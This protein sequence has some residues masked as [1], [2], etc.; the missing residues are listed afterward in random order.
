MN[1]KLMI[2]GRQVIITNEHATSSY[3][4]PVVLVDG[5]ITD[6]GVEYEADRCECNILDMLADAAGIHNG[7][8][9]RRALRSLADEMLPDNPRGG[10]YDPVI[11]EFV[12]RGGR[13]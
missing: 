6:I 10:D 13:Q 3:G 8:R 9:T 1:A 4:L 5:E 12:R 11:D 2:D 7:P